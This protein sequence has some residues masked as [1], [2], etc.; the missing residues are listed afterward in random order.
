MHLFPFIESFNMI[1]LPKYCD[2][3][4]QIFFFSFIF[5]SSSRSY[6]YSYLH[7]HEDF[8]IFFFQEQW[9]FTDNHSPQYRGLRKN[10]KYIK[11]KIKLQ[12]LAT[13]IPLQLASSASWCV[14]GI[15]RPPPSCCRG[16]AC[17]D[18]HHSQ[19]RSQLL[20]SLSPCAKRKL[21]L[22]PRAFSNK[23]IKKIQVCAVHS[24]GNPL[25]L[26]HHNV[27]HQSEGL[28]DCLIGPFKACPGRMIASQYFIIPL[29]FH[30]T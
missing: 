8:F 6:L 5:F 3:E 21:S 25:D 19:D 16:C 2:Q 10:S 15:Q 11:I 23:G 30:S 26:C 28:S 22:C 17:R 14:G 20:H 12:R 7:K 24:D 4:I 9:K 13:A 18:Q 29:Y 27:F 1:A